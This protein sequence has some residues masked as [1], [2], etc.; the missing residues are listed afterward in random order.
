MAG[1]RD[2][3]ARLPR[4]PRGLPTTTAAYRPSVS[5]QVQAAVA[6]T[7]LCAVVVAAKGGWP[8]SARL[9]G[10]FLTGLALFCAATA[11]RQ[12]WAGPGWV[13]SRGLLRTR[14]IRTAE[15]A[16]AKDVRSGVDRL[17]V[18]RDERG[19]RLGLMAAEL[20][21]SPAVLAQIRSDI[22]S[23]RTAGLALPPSTAQLLGLSD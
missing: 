15:L 19:G 18:L 13:A 4:A 11:R 23:R 12:V 7:A 3:R 17:V 5:S 14:V 8:P 10:F 16:S 1:M 2:P 9:S 21:E 22:A 20:R 6:V